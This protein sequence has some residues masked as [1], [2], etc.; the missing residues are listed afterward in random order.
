MRSAGEGSTRQPRTGD[1][2]AVP[3]GDGRYGAVRVLA[4]DGGDR[5]ALFAVTPWL[6][7][8]P[9]LDEPKLRRVLVQN[10]A[11]YVDEPALVFRDGP[12]PSEFRYLG[13]IPPTEEELSIDVKGRY[14]GRLDVSVVNPVRWEEEY[15]HE[16]QT[17]VPRSPTPVRAAA[18]GG[19]TRELMS[20]ARFWELI[21]FLGSDDD[22]AFPNL[23][24]LMASLRELTPKDLELFHRRLHERLHQLDR[25]D[26]A[27]RLS[28]Y[29]FGSSYFSPD[30]FLDVR[31]LVVARGRAHYESVR[32]GSEPVP[33]ED[34]FEELAS[35]AERAHEQRFETPPAFTSDHACETYSNEEGWPH[36][37]DE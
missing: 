11:R 37:P 3:T 13:S 24:S 19:R 7:D 20:E 27:R 26:V 28:R 17:D 8:V 35:V 16:G 30:H 5:S 10:R 29:A 9:A 22:A 34:E 25:E 23:E 1:V 4:T 12:I 2:F 21:E 6:G 32:H 33:A 15:E 36:A 18:R 14:G 31:C